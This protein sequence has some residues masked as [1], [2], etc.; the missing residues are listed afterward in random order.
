[1][2]EKYLWT[3][4]ASAALCDFLGPMLV[5]DQKKRSCARDLVNHEWLETEL[6]MEDLAGF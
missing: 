6:T 2:V 5:V 4:Q 1:M 3:P